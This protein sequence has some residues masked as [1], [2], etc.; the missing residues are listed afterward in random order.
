MSNQQYISLFKTTILAFLSLCL[1]SCEEEVPID[2]SNSIFKRIIV[3]GRI[4]NEFK[5]QK[6]RLTETSAYFDT[7]QPPPITNAEVWISEKKSGKRYNLNLESADSGIYASEKF[8]GTV[9][10]TYLLHIHYNGEDFE[11]EALLHSITPLDSIN[12]VYKYQGYFGYAFGS[13]NIQMSALEPEPIGDYYRFFIY[14]ND[15]LFNETATGSIMQDDRF[16]N[17]YYLANVDIFDL[18]QEDVIKD[19]NTIRVDMLSI[20]KDEYNYLN[21]LMAETWGNGSIFSGPS[22]NIR[23]NIINKSGGKNGLGLFSASAISSRTIIIIKQ[24]DDAT[25]DPN[26]KRYNK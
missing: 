23:S 17:G 24:H 21:E 11:S 16:F 3:E 20:S 9:G 4:T 15:T 1:F 12:Y 19:T 7:T 14:Y 2:L 6:I 25:N 13:Y 22:A 26:Y 5:Q 8:L 18:R 10:E